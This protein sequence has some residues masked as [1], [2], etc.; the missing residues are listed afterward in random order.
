MQRLTRQLASE[1]ASCSARPLSPLAT[2]HPATPLRSFQASAAAAGKPKVAVAEAPPPRWP[3][4]GD[5]KAN[6]RQY[7]DERAAYR[8]ELAALRNTWQEHVVSH[9]NE[10]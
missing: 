6:G 3:W 2:M 8:R 5:R 9:N 7:N 1:L 10:V 4:G